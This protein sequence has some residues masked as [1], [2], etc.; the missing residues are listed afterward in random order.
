MG[1]Q[2]VIN[3]LIKEYQTSIRIV[4]NWLST[5]FKITHFKFKLCLSISL[6][7]I[8]KTIHTFL[9]LFNLMFS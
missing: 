7:K 1:G 5:Q 3:H 6:L 4:I 8:Y 2:D 9:L